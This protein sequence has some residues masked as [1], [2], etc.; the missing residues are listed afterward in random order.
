MVIYKQHPDNP[1]NTLIDLTPTHQHLDLSK[2]LNSGQNVRWWGI[3]SD[4]GVMI[5]PGVSPV[6]SNPGTT[7]CTPYWIG[8]HQSNLIALEQYDTQH[9]RISLPIDRAQEFFEEYF[10]LGVDYS[11]LY[12]PSNNYTPY[13]NRILRNGIGL[14]VMN[15]DLWQTTITFIISQR[16]SISRIQNTVEKISQICGDEIVIERER[17]W[18]PYLRYISST[19]FY[20]FPT[21]SQILN[22][23][24]KLGEIGLGYRD[25]YILSICEDIQSIGL[26]Q[27]NY[28]YLTKYFK[29][30]QQ[31][32]KIKMEEFLISRVGIGEKVKGC[33][34][35]FGFHDRDSFPIDV[36]I[37]RVL[38]KHFPNG[39]DLKSFHGL[40]GVIQQYMF[41]TIR[42]EGSN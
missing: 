14:R 36:W 21:P 28:K 22:K 18:G 27:Y 19:H 39:I 8:I 42:Y 29:S 12:D 31:S 37:Q 34:M 40:S 24:E 7:Y 9:F 16:N 4:G 5:G 33:I 6:N 3:G 1:L 11:I 41:Y 20:T 26:T 38:D 30:K 25:R 17:Y 13:I 23:E 35:L 10:D 15:Q 2:T 32:P